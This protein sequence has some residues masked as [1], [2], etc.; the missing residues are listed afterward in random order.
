VSTWLA[1][2]PVVLEFVP[3]PRRLG[4]EGL[5][6]RLRRLERQLEQFPFSA[7]NLPEIR[8]EPSRSSDGERKT[9]F[10]PRFSPRSIAK[11]I[12]RRF[13]IPS[14]I[15]HVVSTRPRDDLSEWLLEA[16]E[17][18][19]IDDFVLVGPA[20]SDDLLVGPS[21]IEAN[22]IA[23]DC[24]PATTRIGNI[25]IPGRNA[26][27]IAE[28]DRMENKAAAGVHFFTSQI[29]YHAA[30]CRTLL[31]ELIERCPQA[32]RA[33]ILISLCPLRSAESIA[34]LRWL[35]VKLDPPTAARLTLDRESVLERS[36]EHLVGVWQRLRSHVR[37][38]KIPITL[39]LNIAPVGPLPLRATIDL[40]RTL[41]PI[42]SEK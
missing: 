11:E 15:N 14:I 28:A 42:P 20:S 8:E 16:H 22:E 23:R 4:E 37:E 36:I 26:R 13:G 32:S 27:G 31:D 33:T 3:P 2:I 7:V 41:V 6:R 9:P 19:E 38:Q 12:R 1:E 17:D 39:G 21:V 5:E 29:L 30:P 35:G 24:L 10:E 40:A 25:C 18:Y 34:F